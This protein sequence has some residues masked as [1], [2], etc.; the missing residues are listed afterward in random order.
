VLALPG[1]P[2]LVWYFVCLKQSLALEVRT[3]LANSK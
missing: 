1:A 3:V 2:C